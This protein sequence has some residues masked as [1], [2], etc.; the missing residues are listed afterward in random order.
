MVALHTQLALR[1]RSHLVHCDM[2]FE[3]RAGATCRCAR[4]GPLDSGLAG[5]AT[6]RNCVAAYILAWRMLHTRLESSFIARSPCIRPV[7][8][9]QRA[10]VLIICCLVHCSRAL[11]LGSCP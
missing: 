7:S 3:V 8:V 9:T 4:Y 2:R 11:D 6:C 10:I 5:V 1:H